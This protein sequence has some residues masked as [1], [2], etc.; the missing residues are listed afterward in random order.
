MRS[1][2]EKSRVPL[3]GLSAGW[4]LDNNVAG[5]PKMGDVIV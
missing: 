1:N 5:S 2:K 3:G 4:V